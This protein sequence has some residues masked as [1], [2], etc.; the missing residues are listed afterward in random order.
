MEL[1]KRCKINKVETKNSK[2]KQKYCT[3]C[4][5]Y[6]NN[7]MNNIGNNKKEKSK[8]KNERKT[9]Q[10]EKI[11]INLNF[12][13][14][15]EIKSNENIKIEENFTNINNNPEYKIAK[16]N[17]NF[18]YQNLYQKESQ[19][20]LNKINQLLTSNDFI[21]SSNDINNFDENLYLPKQDDINMIVLNEDND[22]NFNDFK[23]LQ[24]II[25]EQREK[26]NEL[27]LNQNNLKNIINKKDLLIEKLNKEKESINE[28]TLT[29][30]KS[31][32]NESEELKNE[33]KKEKENI[34][35]NYEEKI[36]KMNKDY[37]INKSEFDDLKKI[38]DKLENEIKTKEIEKLKL[39]EENQKYKSENEIFKKENEKLK[40]ELKIN[41]DENEI[42][43]EIIGN[44]AKNNDI[45]KSNDKKDII[46]FK[47]NKK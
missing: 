10:N 15:N 34:I 14:N 4:D 18:E 43:K 2:V 44:N 5:Y 19:N 32:Q 11:N 36:S 12:V 25:E 3:L 7:I 27:K 42:L 35:I 39:I 8:L 26:I 38:V 40:K 16:N 41:I 1:C 9:N 23:N 30:Q 22:D 47:K 45:R 20:F 24:K 13:N 17:T 29:V 46:K 37:I 31:L 28:K 21:D 6:I 33:F